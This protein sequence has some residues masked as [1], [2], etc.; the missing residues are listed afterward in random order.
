MNNQQQIAFDLAKEWRI[1][2]VWNKA[3]KIPGIN[4]NLWR[5]DVCGHL[6]NRYEYGN[7]HS[8]FGWE[9][10][11]ITPSSKGGSDAIWNLRPLQAQVNASRQAGYL[12]CSTLCS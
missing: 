8:D 1:Q 2:S 10:D 3:N 5:Q 6:I 11:H 12:N 7:R 9:I 4:L